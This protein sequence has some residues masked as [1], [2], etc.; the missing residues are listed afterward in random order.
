MPSFDEMRLAIKQTN[1][2]RTPRKYGIPLELLKAVYPLILQRLNKL[3]IHISLKKDIPCDFRD[4]KVVILF[5]NKG[6]EYDCG[7]Y[8]VI[9]L[10]SVVRKMTC[11]CCAKQT[12]HLH[13]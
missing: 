1:S 3:L 6:S 10:L 9:P 13:I 4:A 2:S 8:S 7:K 5:M 11:T 12:Y